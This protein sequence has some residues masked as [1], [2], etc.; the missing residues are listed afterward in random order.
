MDTTHQEASEA[1]EAVS[2]L[3]TLSTVIQGACQRLHNLTH[4]KRYAETQD[5]CMRLHEVRECAERLQ[6][7]LEA[8]LAQTTSVVDSKQPSSNRQHPKA[9]Y[10]RRASQYH[11]NY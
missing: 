9:H 11:Y 3:V 6:Q 4:G 7:L 10:N 5:I 1:L 2:E 8:E